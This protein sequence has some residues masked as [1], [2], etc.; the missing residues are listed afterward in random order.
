[1]RKLERKYDPR[2]VVIGVHSAKFPAEQPTEAVREAAARYGL[3]HPIVNDREFL[4][5]RRY[6]VRAW[7]T[8]IF[9]DPLGRPIGKHEGEFDYETF[10]ALIGAML[11]EFEAAGEIDPRP[12]AALVGP[13]HVA[14]GP[15][16][17]PGKVAVDSAG[18]RL[19]I[20]DTNHHRIVQVDLDGRFGC[21]IGSGEPGLVD[22][23][24]AS[25]CFTQPQGLA[26]EPE[27][28]VL[29]VADT[30][31]HAV[32]GVDL[33][34][35]R[36]ETLAGTG[37]QSR[38]YLAPGQAPEPGRSGGTAAGR[39]PLNSP[40]DLT[41]RGRALYI[42]MAGS[43]QVWR[44]DLAGGR[45]QPFAGS[46][47]E[48]LEDGPLAQAWLAQPSGITRDDSALYIADSE[49]SGIRRIDLDGPRP[50]VT[51]LVGRG[52]FEFGDIDGVG[53]AVRLQHPLGVLWD[54]ERNCLWIADTY[55]H[56]I[57]RLDLATRRVDTVA[58][59]GSPGYQD[60]PADQARFN[61]PS[62]LARAD[63]RLFVADTNNHRIR[64]VDLATGAVSTLELHGVPGAP[65]S[66]LP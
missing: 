12:V 47:R 61:E 38:R 25:A 2:L 24:L 35:G 8:L 59:A 10:D 4:I 13:A 66:R 48:G 65:P 63:G 30:E 53:E 34:A 49:V 22:G 21:V 40:W 26:C 60:G 17:F 5:W 1:M 7:P 11:R 6:G 50:L 15:L 51:T 23:D 52:L 43:H 37:E 54:R 18:E 3:A 57:K 39:I 20:A 29:Y 19:Y 27:G 14:S 36:V 56:K 42:A 9:I 46:G 64:V 58:G 45:V 32:R 33:D 28:G 55:N 62:G 31:N 41:L 44:L 16:A